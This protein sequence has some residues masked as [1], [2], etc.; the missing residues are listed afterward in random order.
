VEE[1]RAEGVDVEL[2]M[3]QGVPNE[4]VLR[5]IAEADVVADQL[6]VGWYAMFALEALSMGTPVLCYLRPD[7]VDLYEHAG[8]VTRDEIP[9]ITCDPSNVKETIRAIALDRGLLDG[10][11]EKGHAFVEK[12]HSLRSV[13]A[14]FDRINRA[15]G[16]TPRGAAAPD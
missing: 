2:V 1:L 5:A 15:A 12:H 9:I 8:L 10:L 13:G 7:L 16:I 11:P 3:L 6:V 4:E 14:T